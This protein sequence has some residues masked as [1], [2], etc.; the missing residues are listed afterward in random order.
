MAIFYEIK[1][2]ESEVDAEFDHFT[3]LNRQLNLLLLFLRCMGTRVTGLKSKE[4][5]V[6][7]EKNYPY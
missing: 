6:K 1:T 5:F 7:Y 2:I 3:I 4:D